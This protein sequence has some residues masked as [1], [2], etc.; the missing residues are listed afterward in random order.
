MDLHL[1]SPLDSK[2]IQPVHQ[3][4]SPEYSLERLML[5]LKLQ[6]SGHLMWRTDSLEKTLMLGKIEGRRR[7]ERKRMRWLDGISMDVSL[8]KLEGLEAGEEG[9]DRGWDGWMS[10]P[11]W[12][13][14]VWLNSRSWG[15][16]GRP[17]MLQFMGSQT[18]G[19]D[20]TSEL[21]D[22]L[23]ENQRTNNKNAC[24]LPVIIAKFQVT[25]LI[26][27]S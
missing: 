4:I 1:E 7:R 18:V 13:T 21:T 9:D 10:S 15:W 3:E 14:W 24:N 19:D 20:W 8:N 11:T 26:Y 23:T 16:T 22:W 2:E 27:K 25:R 5:K 6:Y 17:G 12:W